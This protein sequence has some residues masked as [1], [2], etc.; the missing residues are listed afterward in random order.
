MTFG[1]GNRA[2]RSIVPL[3]RNPCPKCGGAKP[4]KGRSPYMARQTAV[5]RNPNRPNRAVSYPPFAKAN[6]RIG[7]R[8]RQLRWRRRLGYTKPSHT[9]GTLCASFA[10]KII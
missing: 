7:C 3:V 6:E 8:L 2:L 5:L 4:H 9:A 10:G 1:A